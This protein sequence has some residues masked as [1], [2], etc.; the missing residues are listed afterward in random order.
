[1]TNKCTAQAAWDE[2]LFGAAPSSRICGI[3]LLLLLCKVLVAIYPVDKLHAD[4]SPSLCLTENPVYFAERGDY[5]DHTYS[6]LNVNTVRATYY[7]GKPTYAVITKLDD[8]GFDAIS[9][10]RQG[11]YGVVASVLTG[12]GVDATLALLQSII[13]TPQQLAVE[14]G[15]RVM[16]QGMKAM[17][18][19][20]GLYRRGIP[21]LSGPELERFRKNQLYV[22]LMGSGKRL[23]LDSKDTTSETS[24]DPLELD[25]LSSLERV[26]HDSLVLGR[27]LGAVEI[28]EI[29]TQFGLDLESYE[30]YSRYMS[31]VAEVRGRNGVIPCSTASAQQEGRGLRDSNTRK[32]V[33]FRDCPECPEM[34]VIPAGSYT[35]G[36]PKDE[37]GRAVTKEDP[38]HLVTIAGPFAVG[39]YEVTFSEWDACVAAGGCGGYRPDD[40]G[41]GRGR[42]PVINVNWEDAKAYI[43]WL[44]GRTGKAYRLLSE[45]E[46]EYAARAGTTTPFHFGETILTE[47]AN[48]NGRDDVYNMLGRFGVYR[49]KTV[50]VGSFPGNGFRLHDMHGN[51]WEWVEDCWGY[52]SYSGAPTD[53]S[54]LLECIRS[55]FVDGAWVDV[56]S[57]MHGRRGGSWASPPSSLRSARRSAKSADYRS[58]RLGFRVALTVP[59]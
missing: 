29:L 2:A 22:D 35:M 49:M 17:N 25:A 16:A 24:A 41:W 26:F 36:S 6:W 44:T 21:N 54:A 11:P 50:P 31:S 55:T 14:T 48:Y 59:P 57:D 40:E 58:N 13:E 43:Q 18:E 39:K 3:P 28:F 37:I 51:V 15:A 19:N 4:D 20:Y 8:A 38:A 42:Q 34:V 53:G 52:E 12:Q 9:G 30:P 33:E 5:L 27:V 1:M 46:W 45:S 56:P 32:L 47:Q 23:Y 7:I 10:L